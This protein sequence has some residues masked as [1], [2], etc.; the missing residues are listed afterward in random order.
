MLL[1]QCIRYIELRDL[2]INLSLT[3][4][5][6]AQQWVFIKEGSLVII[7]AANGKIEG[8]ITGLNFTNQIN[9]VLVDDRGKQDAEK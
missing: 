6:K 5:R 3:L 9:F 4:F 7:D 1:N 2:L 8:I